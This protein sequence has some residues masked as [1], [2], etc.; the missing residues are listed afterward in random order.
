MPTRLRELPDRDGLMEL[1]TAIAKACRHDPQERYV[2]AAAMRADLERLRSGKSLARLHRVEERLRSVQRAGVLVTAAAALIAA[3]W[4]CQAR[5]TH[6]VRHLAAEKALLAGENSR[7]A[8][9][10]RQ[11]LVRLGVANGGREM[12]RDGCGPALVWLTEALTLTTNNPEDAA[13]QR[14]RIQQLLARHPRLLHVLP[15]PV[16]VVSAE[17][18]PDER[19]VVTGCADGVIR[20]WDLGDHDKPAA[21][22]HPVGLAGRVRFTRDGRRHGEALGTG[23]N[24][25]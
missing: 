23:A 13:I 1:N 10:R 16:A 24:C 3:G 9:E 12:D 19:R 8:D 21:E 25:R 6:L 4:L 2:S 17:F 18:R 11:R 15:H 14:I 7:L 22:F 20:I 5:Q